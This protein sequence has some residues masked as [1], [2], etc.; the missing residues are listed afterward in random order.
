MN[1]RRGPKV[2]NR[3]NQEYHIVMSW[4]KNHQM[5]WKCCLT[6]DS[7]GQNL[8]GPVVGPSYG[9]SNEVQLLVTP[10]PNPPTPTKMLLVQ[11]ATIYK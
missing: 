3:S 5:L 1:A 6:N 8:T 11:T 9:T 10:N 7:I 2:T 4:M